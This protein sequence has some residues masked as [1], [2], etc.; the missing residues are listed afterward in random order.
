[1]FE[2]IHGSAPDIAGK[3]IANPSGLLHGAILMLEHIG[4]AD[5]GVRLTNAWLRTIE[6]GVLTG[7]VYREGHD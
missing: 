7:D 5:V 3:G 4:Q 6:D 2:A 1:M